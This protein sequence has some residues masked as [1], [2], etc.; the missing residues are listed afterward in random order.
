[1]QKNKAKKCRCV[2]CGCDV[3]CAYAGWQMC[4]S[5]KIQCRDCWWQGPK[6]ALDLK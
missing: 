2:K 5:D 4:K 6:E 1:M 3:P